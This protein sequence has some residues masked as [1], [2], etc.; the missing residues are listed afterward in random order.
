VVMSN[1]GLSPTSVSR[2]MLLVT[3]LVVDV[4]CAMLLMLALLMH[5]KHA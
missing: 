1:C 5:L 2:S 4:L 3:K